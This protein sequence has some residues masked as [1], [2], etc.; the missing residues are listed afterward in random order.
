MAVTTPELKPVPAFA[1]TE[2]MLFTFSSVG[3]NQVVSN[4]LIVRNA[5]TLEK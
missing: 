2:D 1:A 3:G 4:K 5:T